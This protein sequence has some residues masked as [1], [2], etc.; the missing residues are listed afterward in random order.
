MKIPEEFVQF[1]WG[2]YPEDDP[3]ESASLES[4][5]AAA[6][7]GTGGHDRGPLLAFLNELLDGGHSDAELEYVWLKQSPRSSFSPGGHR[8]FFEEI[9]RQIIADMDRKLG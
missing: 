6:L 5:A 7:A 4:V 1:V 2:I 8:V 9:R 3:A